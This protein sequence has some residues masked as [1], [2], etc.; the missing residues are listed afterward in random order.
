MLL[1]FFLPYWVCQA[2]SLSWLTGGHRSAFWSEVYETMLC[3]PMSLTVVS[4]LLKPFGKP[5]KVSKKGETRS[6]LTLNPV[7]GMPLIVLLALYIPA[8]IYAIAN[9]EW[10]P[11]Q[12]IF[13]LAIVW[14]AYS[15]ILL[16]LSIQASL[17]VPQHSSSV[18]FKHQLPATLRRRGLTVPVSTEEIS[19][20]D[21]ILRMDA[22]AAGQMQAAESE[23]STVTLSIP[24]CGLKEARVS[25]L[26]RESSTRWVFKLEKLTVDQHRSMI[27]SLYCRAGQWDE[28]GVPEPVTFWH[29]LEAPFRMY[30]LAETR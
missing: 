2:L 26:E 21:V 4:T 13:A 12:S 28:R 16:W 5:F 24:G 14:S 22:D 10:Y 7:V 23:N 30:P 15:M 27:A 8:V 20:T 29:F 25:L 18:R 6:G 17:D 11:N 3:F 9:A 19:D 1:V